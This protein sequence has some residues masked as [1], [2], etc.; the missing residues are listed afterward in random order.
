ML[1]SFS[2][3]FSN[4][5]SVTPASNKV[6]ATDFVSLTEAIIEDILSIPELDGGYSTPTEHWY[7]NT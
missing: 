2:I 3:A 1:G 7:K 5:S 6:T 4:Q